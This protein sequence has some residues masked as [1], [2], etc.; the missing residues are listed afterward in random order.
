MT[1]G[2]GELAIV[3]DYDFGPLS[4]PMSVSKDRANALSLAHD[5]SVEVPL[6]LNIGSAFFCSADEGVQAPL[7]YGEP[8]TRSASLGDVRWNP[9]TDVM[10]LVGE[11]GKGP[12]PAEDRALPGQALERDH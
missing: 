2:F 12:A 6:T 3:G 1:V 11:A 5:L 8:L 9:G 7:R 4:P 10:R